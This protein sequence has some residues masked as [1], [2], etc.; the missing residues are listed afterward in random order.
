MKKLCKCG[1]GQEIVE[2]YHHRYYGSPDYI[3]GHNGR[4]PDG[5]AAKKRREYTKAWK[6]QNKEYV[7]KYNKELKSKNKYHR[8]DKA[9][10]TL[11]KRQYDITLDEYREMSKLQN[12]KCLICGRHKSEFKKCLCVD[13]NHDTG[14]IRG[15]LC[16]NCNM[17]LGLLKDDINIIKNMVDYVL[18]YDS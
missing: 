13:H 18:K 7:S 12:H 6:D 9:R 3:H 16:S 4:L 11:L 2:K 1:C 10:D 14:K 17:A 8:R 5:V 15:L